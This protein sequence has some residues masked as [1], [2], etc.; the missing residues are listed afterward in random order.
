MTSCQLA[1][2]HL[3]GAML[4]STSFLH[5]W[6]RPTI[7]ADDFSVMLTVKSD[8]TLSMKQV[9]A[10]MCTRGDMIHHHSN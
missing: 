8:Y 2:S 4:L 1:Y 5:L 10:K 9:A 6:Y 3:C 7:S